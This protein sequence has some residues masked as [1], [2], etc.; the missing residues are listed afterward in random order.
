MSEICDRRLEYDQP[1][2]VSDLVQ[3]RVL[4]L[5]R[6]AVDLESHLAEIGEKVGV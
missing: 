6:K 4:S 5:L 1:V 2:K 3:R